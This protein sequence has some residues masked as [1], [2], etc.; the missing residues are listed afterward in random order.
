M[1]LETNC[2]KCKYKQTVPG[3]AHIMCTK[4]DPKMTGDPHGI[5]NGWFIYPVLF[6][7]IWRT[8]ECDNFEEK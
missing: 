6:D 4:P 3:N 8:K 7:P 5:R 2:Y 1:K